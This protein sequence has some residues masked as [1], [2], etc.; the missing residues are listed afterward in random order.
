MTNDPGAANLI[1]TASAGVERLAGA[2]TSALGQAGPAGAV[3]QPVVDLLRD[4]WE[5]YFGSP[6]PQGDTN[7]NAY[8][9]QQLYD[10]LWQHADAGQVGGVASE[11]GQHGAELTSQAVALRDQRTALQS[12]WTGAAAE[13]AANRLGQLS[14]QTHGIGTR[15]GTVQQATQNAGDGLAVA[16]NTMP[17]P[18]GDPTGLAVTGAVAGAGAGAAIG[19]IAGAA[20]GG[21]GAGPGALMGAAIGAVAGGA[22]SLFLAS[23]LAAQKKAEAVHVMVRYEAS[24]RDSSTALASTQSA[25]TTASPFGTNAFTTSTAGYAGVGS[26]GGGYSPGG[27]APWQQLVGTGPLSSRVGAGFASGVGALDGTLVP[28][29]GLPPEAIPAEGG[30]GGGMAPGTGMGARGEEDKEH[31]NRLP[32]VDHRLFTVDERTTTPVIGL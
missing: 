31:H 10:M 26:P 9:H 28:R 12:N 30:T 14:D 25:V 32:V 23:V 5:G 24:L 16:R 13:P 1:D 7:W 3:V 21:V 18:P 20:A 8:T 22:G 4:V 11:W 6:I 19:G 2:A 15:A 29:T 27:G 17:P